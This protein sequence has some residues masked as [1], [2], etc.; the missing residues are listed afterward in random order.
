M[1]DGDI[2]SQ[3]YRLFSP[4]NVPSILFSMYGPVFGVKAR[5]TSK[6]LRVQIHD[7]NIIIATNKGIYDSYVVNYKQCSIDQ[8]MYT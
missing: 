7:R 2:G 8:Y 5:L 4:R 6:E 1:V 3:N